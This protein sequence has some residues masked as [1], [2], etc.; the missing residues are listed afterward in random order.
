MLDSTVA[1]VLRN[2]YA[3]LDRLGKLLP[4]G[5]LDEC[6]RTFR[7][8]FGPQVLSAIDG[9]VLL[10]QMH[11][12]GKGDTLV[13]WLE[14]K[15][16]EEFPARFGSISG[17]SALKFGIYRRKETGEWM[18]G[19]S[20]DQRKISV[21]EAVEIARK[22]RQQ[23]IDGCEVLKGYANSDSPVNYDKLQT[24]LTQVA[25]DVADSSWG[26]KY[27]SLM[28]PK[29][30]DDYHNPN[31]Q[32][33]HLIKSLVEPPGTEGRYV[34]A[35]LFVGICKELGWPMNH[36][37]TVMNSRNGAPHSY[38]RIGTRHGGSGQSEWDSMRANSYVSIGWGELGDL[39]HLIYDRES[40][41]QLRELHK[42]KYSGDP[43]AVGRKV[44]QI[45]NFVTVLSDGDIVLASDGASVLGIGR[46]TGDYQY[47]ASLGFPHTR[48]VEWLSL[49]PWKMMQPEG[50][51]TTVF[52]LGKYPKN[53]IDCER[54]CLTAAQ[55]VVTVQR[56][57]APLPPLTGT[58]ARVQSIMDRKGQVI[59]YGPPGTGKTF[60]GEQVVGEL[61]ARSN[62]GCTAAAL[63]ADQKLRVDPAQSDSFVRVCCFHPSYGYEDFVEGYRPT[64][65][66]GKLTFELRDGIFKSLCNSAAKQP[67]KKFYLLIDEINR[68]DIPRIF[69]ELIMLIEKNKRGKTLQLPVSGSPFA[70]PPNL[71]IIGT[72]NTADRSIAL[73]DT[74]L[75]RR[76]GFIE[77]MP[78]YE[79]LSGAVIHGVPVGQWL[80][81]LNQR[82]CEIVG[83]DA[84]NLQIGHSYLM[85]R[86]KPI[87]TIE[88][89]QRAVR[90]DIIPLLQEYCYE[91][92]SLL[93]K[94][95]GSGFVNTHDMTFNES[96]C[97]P[98]KYDDFVAA[99]L[100]PNP[101]ISTSADAVEAE[102][103][104]LEDDVDS[105]E[106]D[107]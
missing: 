70:V 39:S 35:G 19:S 27:L 57:E 51:Q 60:Y 25:P 14:F 21:P 34:C 59:L 86:A 49:E 91:D 66:D 54:H 78:D 55:T 90:Q 44:Q 11:G 103:D 61:A 26:H 37:T 76:F 20:K 99:L 73:L 32:R 5:K 97:T 75:R 53:L 87:Q 40:K 13:Y 3:K 7:Q 56:P 88:Q 94:L 42:Q 71:A 74:A 38:W 64:K 30:L 83:R 92:F 102:S 17:G 95:L 89:L 31:Y 62:F 9:E 100:K 4:Q 80:K 48:S 33:Y 28:F 107:A 104:L 79:L 6:Y 77:M 2:E 65:A 84:R 16:D 96:L 72:M 98:E 50:L 24:S 45:F 69:G 63:T 47:D 8:R 1:K 29:I 105:E 36:L 43:R 106:S 46:I 68:G 12:H 22:H 67:E 18:T 81:S 85:E 10:E 58:F 41:E 23:L 93:E 101:S 82:I 52:R 15:D